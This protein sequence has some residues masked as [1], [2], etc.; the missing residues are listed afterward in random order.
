VPKERGKLRGNCRG[1]SRVMGGKYWGTS[2]LST[3]LLKGILKKNC[4]IPLWRID[5]LR[6]IEKGSHIFL[7]KKGH[8]EL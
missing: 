2:L 7:T 8:G 6:K 4:V 1:L 5:K 3:R